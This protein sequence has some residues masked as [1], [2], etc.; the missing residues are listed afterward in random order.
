MKEAE[1]KTTIEL[2]MEEDGK[3]F[4]VV[5]YF[6]TFKV[7]RSEGGHVYKFLFLRKGLL[8]QFNVD[9]PSLEY[10]KNNV[11]LF[12]VVIYDGGKVYD[13]NNFRGYFRANATKNE[14]KKIKMG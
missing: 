10:L 14:I 11:K 8:A 9:L 1:E 6:S 12:K 4:A 7:S 5:R 13:F 2:L 3:P